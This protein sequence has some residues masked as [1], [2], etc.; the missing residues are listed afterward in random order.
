MLGL[1]RAYQLSLSVVLGRRC[2]YL[3]TCSEYTADAIRQYGP[4]PGFWIGLARV[5]RCHPWGGDGFDPVPQSLPADGRW[6]T[7]WR[8]GVWQIERQTQ[9]DCCN[10]DRSD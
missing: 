7:P 1:I 2:R 3:P 5:T 8:Y 10:I 6:Y 4:W 9:D